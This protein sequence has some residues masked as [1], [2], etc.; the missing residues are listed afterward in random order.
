MCCSL[1]HADE[2]GRGCARFFSLHSQGGALASVEHRP[3]DRRADRCAHCRLSS[4][5]G[6]R[7]LAC[8]VS[9]ER[10][11]VPRGHFRCSTR[12][13]PPSHSSGGPAGGDGRDRAST[14]SATP[15][16]AWSSLTKICGYTR[17]RAQTAWAISGRRA[18]LARS[19]RH[20]SRSSQGANL[21]CRRGC[22]GDGR[23][24]SKS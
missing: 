23:R 22:N 20:R 21:H 8:A 24:I 18:A 9:G 15:V 12:I 1:L 10:P 4:R 16:L 3:S 14:G 19:A 13:D 11:L 6:Y 5:R 7:R 17:Q 2:S